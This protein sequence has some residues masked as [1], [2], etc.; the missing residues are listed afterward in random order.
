MDVHIFPW[1]KAAKPKHPFVIENIGFIYDLCR[2][3]VG[4]ELYGKTSLQ[5]HCLINMTI[6]DGN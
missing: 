1:A 3:C 2:S 4:F 5:I 6:F